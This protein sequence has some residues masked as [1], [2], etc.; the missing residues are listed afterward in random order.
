MSIGELS[1]FEEATKIVDLTITECHLLTTIELGNLQNINSIYISTS[2]NAQNSSVRIQ[3]PTLKRLTYFINNVKESAPF[4]IIE[5]QNLK[6]LELSRM[7]V[8]EGFLQNLISTSQVLERLKL[9]QVRGELRERFN[10]C[11]SQSRKV[12]EI[13]YCKN[14]GEIDALN[15]V[16][17]DYVGIEI[18]EV[19]IVKDSGQLGIVWLENKLY[20]D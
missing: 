14:I 11:A 4:D 3:S 19:K 12:L 8:S 7:E 13:Q 17:F 15:L 2:F 18:H 9:E 16:S 5:C 6:S 20:W 10:I 1:F